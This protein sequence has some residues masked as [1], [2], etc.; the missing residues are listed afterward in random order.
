[1]LAA[2]HADSSSSSS[3]SASVIMNIGRLLLQSPSSGLASQSVD[4]SLDKGKFWGL[5]LQFGIITIALSIVSVSRALHHPSA[6]TSTHKVM[7]SLFIYYCLQT[8]LLTKLRWRMDM[9]YAMVVRWFHNRGFEDDA[10]VTDGAG[11]T[12]PDLTAQQGTG[13]DDEQPRRRCC[14]LRRMVWW[15]SHLVRLVIVL[16]IILAVAW[17][18]TAA[19]SLTPWLVGVGLA[20][21]LPAFFLSMHGL[22]LWRSRR[23]RF[24]AS[25]GRLS[26]IQ[27]S[28]LVAFVLFVIFEFFALAAEFS[29]TGAS[30]LFVG[31]NMI[32]MVVISYESVAWKGLGMT[33]R[34]ITVGRGREPLPCAVPVFGFSLLCFALLLFGRLRT[35]ILRRSSMRCRGETGRRLHA[36]PLSSAVWCCTC[37]L[38]LSWWCTPLWCFCLVRARRGSLGK[39]CLFCIGESGRQEL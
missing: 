29:F 6:L 11:A 21:L 22:M 35:N 20:T 38:S 9:V 13:T 3:V 15:C 33:L 39:L 10:V 34:D 19:A 37:L 26:G 28:F 18:L 31:F 14:S 1:M 30:W 32:P 2:L 5:F 23:W 12:S 17:G 24:T 36:S 8:I 27:Q 4:A 25:D 7:T 16:P